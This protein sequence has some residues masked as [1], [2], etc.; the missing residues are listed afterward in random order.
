MVADVN[1][2]PRCAYCFPTMLARPQVWDG[3]PAARAGLAAGDRVLALGSMDAELVRLQVTRDTPDHCIG[4]G[5]V[6]KGAGVRGDKHRAGKARR[7]AGCGSWPP[8]PVG[9]P[10]RPR[11]RKSGSGRVGGGKDGRD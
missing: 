8:R 3:S 7:L 4:P 11:A 1:P 10:A 2:H 9:I 5:L 6:M